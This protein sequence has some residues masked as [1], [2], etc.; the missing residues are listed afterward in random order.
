MFFSNIL[1]DIWMIYFFWFVVWIYF[2]LNLLIIIFF[3][4]FLFF[5][6]LV[7]FCMEIDLLLWSCFG[8]VCLLVGD[9]CCV[10]MVVL[11]II[12]KN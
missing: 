3:K 5:V 8:G 6:D 9:G 11:F 4:N 10:V 12:K 1:N 2:F 7:V